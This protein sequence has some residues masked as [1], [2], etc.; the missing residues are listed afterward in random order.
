[1]MTSTNMAHTDA[2]R[3]RKK[4]KNILKNNNNETKQGKTKRYIVT[5]KIII[6]ICTLAELF[7]D[8]FDFQ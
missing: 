4:R 2:K 6:L 3:K 7:C 1:M 8:G 5:N